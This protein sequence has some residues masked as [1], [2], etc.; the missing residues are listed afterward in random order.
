MLIRI[1]KSDASNWIT[2]F[3]F[4]IRFLPLDVF[5]WIFICFFYFACDLS[6][7]F[8]T[9]FYS[10]IL[11]AKVGHKNFF[12]YF[13][14]PL[15]FAQL[16]M[17]IIVTLQEFSSEIILNIKECEYILPKKTQHTKIWLRMITK[18]PLKANTYD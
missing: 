6:L 18:L 14:D 4:L 3:K 12:Y 15:L 9:F 16:Y 13:V 1:R 10:E 11:V 2:N 17:L 8:A 5:S 7:H